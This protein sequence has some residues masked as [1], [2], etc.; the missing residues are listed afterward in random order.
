VGPLDGLVGGEG[1]L[2]DG[3]PGEAGRP[4]AIARGRFFLGIEAIGSSSWSGARGTRRSTASSRDQ[5]LLDHVAR[6]SSRGGA[7]AL[8]VAGL[9][10]E[11][12]ALL[13]G[14]LDVLHVLV[15]L[16]ELGP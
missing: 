12:L 8:A 10:H 7:G 5:L 11:Q 6:R 14:E 16:L 13:D 2:A 1:E 9:Q 15:V 3:T 4:L